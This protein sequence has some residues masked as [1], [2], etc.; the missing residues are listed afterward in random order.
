MDT[1]NKLLEIS[2]RL[3]H[4]EKSAEWIAK[5]T[6]HSDNGISQTGTLICVLTDQVREQVYSLV[7]ALEKKVEYSSYH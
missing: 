4:L 3:E 5:E 1:I 2:N 7:K 6:V